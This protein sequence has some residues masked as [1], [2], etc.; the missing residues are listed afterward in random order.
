VRIVVSDDG[1]GFDPPAALA[2]AGTT[3]GFGLLRIR[4]RM[5]MFG[6]ELVMESAAGSGSRFTLVG[7]GEP[8]PPGDHPDDS[9]RRVE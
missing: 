5:A 2:R 3:G 9:P 6:G 8:S 7:P 4:E 1:V